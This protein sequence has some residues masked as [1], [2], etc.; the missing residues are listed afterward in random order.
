M[1]LPTDN[2]ASVYVAH[3]A[4]VDRVIGYGKLTANTRIFGSASDNERML[5]RTLLGGLRPREPLP[6][7]GSDQKSNRF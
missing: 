3:D 4:A 1:V 2:G 6:R 5:L 7:I